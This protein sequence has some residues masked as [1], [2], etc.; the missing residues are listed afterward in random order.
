MNGRWSQL[1][2]AWRA[3]SQSWPGLGTVAGTASLADDPQ[4]AS[5]VDC[6]TIAPAVQLDLT[7]ERA[8]PRSA[9]FV[10]PA[11]QA[12]LLQNTTVWPATGAAVDQRRRVLAESVLAPHQLQTLL[13]RGAFRRFPIQTISG[14]ATTLLLGPYW[15]NHY[16][17]LIDVLP[18]TFALHDR[19]VASWGPVK[20]LIPEDLSDDRR[21]LLSALLPAWVEP[22]RVSPQMR[23]R[24]ERFLLPPYF[25]GDEAG[26]LPAECAEF[27]RTQ[28]RSAFDVQPD[29]R[30]RRRIL[31][32]RRRA[33]T[34]RIV[35]QDELEA[36][37]GPLGFETFELERL[38]F[39][40]QIRLFCEAECVVGPHGAGLS[41]LLFAPP[42]RVLELGVGPPRRHYRVLAA[43]LGHEYAN[44]F[45]SGTEKNAEFTAPVA[46][47]SA[48]LQE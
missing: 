6:A 16:H 32:S 10:A 24:P 34:R 7:N 37:L 26:Y 14:T 13:E 19:R 21:R 12:Y 15:N 22:M 5:I 48:V 35:N 8:E 11:R 38:S 30:R 39:A 41:N 47:V 44:R 9:S 42:C 4:H 20:L 3:W 23:I 17:W 43:A 45:V 36:A 33:A 27:L 46:E 28:A 25:S 31:I 1:A 40:E 2:A 29:P 18:R